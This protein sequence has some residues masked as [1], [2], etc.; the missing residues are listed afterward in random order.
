MSACISLPSHRSS[1]HMSRGR[2]LSTPK[3][4]SP[5]TYQPRPFVLSTLTNDQLQYLLLQNHPYADK[6]EIHTH[7]SRLK[8]RVMSGTGNACV[9]RPQARRTKSYWRASVQTL[10]LYEFPMVFICIE[11]YPKNGDVRVGV[12]EYL[13]AKQI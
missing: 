1:W 3:P 6:Y 7:R 4:L 13:Y 12:V 8:F 9:R 5:I 11:G 10:F 2:M